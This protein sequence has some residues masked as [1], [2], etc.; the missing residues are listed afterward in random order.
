MTKKSRLSRDLKIRLAIGVVGLVSLLVIYLW[1]TL[2]TAADLALLTI[3]AGLIFDF[4]WERNKKLEEWENREDGSC[5]WRTTTAFFSHLEADIHVVDPNEQCELQIYPGYDQGKD[6]QNWDL[7]PSIGSKTLPK[8]R[9]FE[10]SLGFI[11]PFAKTK[12]SG[13]TSS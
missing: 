7:A 6:E 8:T 1:P 12:M 4:V 5:S 3:M 10:R 11:F 13:L 9:N 2:G